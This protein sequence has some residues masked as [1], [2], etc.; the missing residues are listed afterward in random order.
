MWDGK[1][2][3]L[4]GRVT[5]IQSVLSTIPIYYLSMFLLPKNSLS[6]I[7]RVQHSFLWGEDESNS[8]IPWVI[9][10]RYV[11]NLWKGGWVLKMLVF[12]KLWLENG[13]GDFYYKGIG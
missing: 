5:L 2:I 8:K 10:V 6:A 3:S 9:R 7:V 12:S 1:N 4:G 11:E 13:Y